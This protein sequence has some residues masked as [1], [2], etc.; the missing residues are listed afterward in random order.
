MRQFKQIK[1]FTRYHS[2]IG[3]N[4]GSSTFLIANERRE[5]HHSVGT[6]INKKDWIDTIEQAI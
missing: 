5:S 2:R 6:K 3:S 4:Q 1:S